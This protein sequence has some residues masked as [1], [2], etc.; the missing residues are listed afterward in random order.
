MSFLALV[1]CR[2]LLLP[3][4]AKHTKCPQLLAQLGLRASRVAVLAAT[5]DFIEH[6]LMGMRSDTVTRQLY[7]MRGDATMQPPANVHHRLVPTSVKPPSF[8]DAQAEYR[9]CIDAVR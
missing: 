1:S 3:C 6:R 9:R 4:V 2:R 8:R 5:D 7:C